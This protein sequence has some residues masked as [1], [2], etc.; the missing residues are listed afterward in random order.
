MTNYFLKPIT[1]FRFSTIILTLCLCSPLG[2][3]ASEEFYRWTGEDGTIHY[4]STPP[5]GVKAELVKTTVT[6]APPNSQENSGE[7]GASNGT[8]NPEAPQ[9][10]EEQIKEQKQLC[11]DERKRVS[12]LSKPGNRIRMQQAD[13]STKYLNQQE[14]SQELKASK[15]YVEQACKGF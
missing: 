14:V 3:G 4:G 11:S 13:G 1:Q 12:A 2:H 7:A 9:L 6:K 5:Q 15:D 10:T 8:A